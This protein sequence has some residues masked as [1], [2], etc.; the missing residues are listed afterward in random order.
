M[1]SQYSHIEFISEPVK[2]DKGTFDTA[3]M[4][5]GEPGIPDGFVWRE[6]HYQITDLIDCWKESESEN[7][8]VSGE[9]YYR[10][11]FFVVRVNTN[12][13]MTLYALRHTKTGQS[14]KQR[15]WLYTITRDNI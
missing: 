3:A 2:P 8:T 1:P 4:A 6:K 7:H 12:E 14:A 11:R 10:K 15:W 9:K 13:I 5:R